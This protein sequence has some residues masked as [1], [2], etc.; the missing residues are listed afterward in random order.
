MQPYV[1]EDQKVFNEDYIMLRIKITQEVA[2]WKQNNPEEE[3][4]QNPVIS[5]VKEAIS[6]LVEPTQKLSTFRLDAPGKGLEFETRNEGNGLIKLYT[7]LVSW[8]PVAQNEV[9]K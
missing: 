4:S 1:D 7:S 2:K 8:E 9:A 3:N 5:Y 6:S